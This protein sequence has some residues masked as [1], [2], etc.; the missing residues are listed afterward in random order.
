[1]KNEMN[2]NSAFELLRIVAMFMIVWGHCMLA[3]AQNQEPYL[4]TLDNIGWF[5]SAFTVCAV[6]LFFL[7]TGYF[8]QSRNY[9]WNKTVHI[10]L[11]TILYSVGI[12]LIVSLLNG[13]FEWKTMLSFCFPVFLKK[14][15]FMQVYI[16]LAF[17]T[18]YIA[19]TLEHLDKKKHTIL[20]VVLLL[21][22]CV[23]ETFIKVSMTLDQTQGYGIIWA[24]TLLIVGNWLKR[25]GNE[26]IC[27]ISG[28]GWN[29]L[30]VIMSIM[31]FLSNYII[32]KYNIASGITS[33]G[34]FYAY[35]SLTVF[36]QSAF[37]FCAFIQLSRKWEGDTK[38]WINRI[39]K[40]TLAVY[41]IS[42]HPLLLY[43]IWTD[44]LPMKCL[45]MMPMY[46]I[47]SAVGTLVVMTICIFSDI[48][49]E[50]VLKRASRMRE[51][52]L[53]QIL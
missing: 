46:V 42:A 2:R 23:H 28:L 37:L 30:Y 39:G 4:G 18:P 9:K 17:L 50:S 41:L 19:Y 35:N 14:Y 27:K 25:Y 3:T 7:L 49:L 29:L 40:N 48:M 13:T 51:K 11:K 38:K 20:V 16:V 15:W 6:N 36:L 34:N 31:I 53:R 43:P 45:T 47:I 33:R 26:Y 52:V 10:W 21:F 5:V 1:M 22:F 12:Y 44:I 32:V 24:C 8:A